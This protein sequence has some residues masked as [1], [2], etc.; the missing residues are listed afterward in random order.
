MSFAG[1]L[2]RQDDSSREQM[3]NSR[4][5]QWPS[6]VASANPVPPSS[7]VSVTGLGAFTQIPSNICTTLQ[8]RGFERTAFGEVK[9]V[10]V[11]SDMNVIL[12]FFFKPR[13][14]ECLGS[15]SVDPCACCTPGSPI[16]PSSPGAAPVVLRGARAP[17]SSRPRPS[18][19]AGCECLLLP[20]RT[21]F[22]F[23]W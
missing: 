5:C 2:S 13:G 22:L 9:S 20:V 10:A 1:S 4:R 6:P 3:K 17:Q 19:R 16:M 14:K 8:C 15:Q 18:L 23:Y 11:T 21:L 7:Y 12:V